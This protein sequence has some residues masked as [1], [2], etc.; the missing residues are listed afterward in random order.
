M[1]IF[2]AMCC[3]LFFSARG[4]ISRCALCSF[5]GRGGSK[6][7]LEFCKVTVFYK[8]SAAYVAVMILFQKLFGLV[9]KA[10]PLHSHPL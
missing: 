8:D 4:E 6:W 1:T 3:L 2:C 5:L 9:K 10:S 7:Q